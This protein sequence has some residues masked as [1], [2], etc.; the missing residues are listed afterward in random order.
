MRLALP[1]V[2]ML[3]VMAC[4]LSSA[5]T[6]WAVHQ[7][8]L[9]AASNAAALQADAGRRAE[10]EAKRRVRS[11][12]WRIYIDML[13]AWQVLPDQATLDDIVATLRADARIMDGIDLSEAPLE[14][15]LSLKQASQAMVAYS[16]YWARNPL[17]SAASA[18]GARA[19]P[20]ASS[21]TSG[22]MLPLP[23]LEAVKALGGSAL[24][25]DEDVEATRQLTAAFVRL[26]KTMHRY[27]VI[28]CGT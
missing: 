17:R 9:T 23:D 14:L 7:R 15:A 18:A 3:V 28:I 16:N 26:G 8:M 5:L 21:Y 27:G 25:H 24:A 22:L 1:I 2:L 6:G 19:L 20:T 10:A 4:A 11:Q 12:A 13:R